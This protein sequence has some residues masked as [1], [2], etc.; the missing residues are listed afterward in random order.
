M[1]THKWRD[2]YKDINQ[3]CESGSVEVIFRATLSFWFWTETMTRN[4]RNSSLARVAMRW[5]QVTFYP[6]FLIGMNQLWRR[7]WHWFA[8]E[9]KPTAGVGPHR[10]ERTKS[11]Q[12]KVHTDGSTVESRSK[13]K[14][15][16]IT[17]LLLWNGKDE[18]LWSSYV[19]G[20]LEVQLIM[21]K[22]PQIQNKRLR[23]EIKLSKGDREE[24]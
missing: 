5:R 2:K 10:K 12:R 17:R 4:G 8:R 23:K 14:R 13:G 9:E 6:K 1:R 24:Q 18:S 21:R 19:R 22:I 7:H 15:N 3:Q 16:N 20:M 11:G